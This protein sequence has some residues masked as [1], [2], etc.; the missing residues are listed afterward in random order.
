M[1]SLAR[2]AAFQTQGLKLVGQYRACFTATCASTRPQRVVV[3]GGGLAGL[4][5]SYHLLNQTAVVAQAGGVR[6]SP[7]RITIFDEC[8]VGEGGASGA[9]AGLLHP[10]TPRGKKMW[11]G[12]EGFDSSLR[13][14]QAAVEASSQ[15]ILSSSTGKRGILRLVTK[16]EKQLKDYL[17][18]A[19]LAP[20]EL[21]FVD[22]RSSID[23]A[24]GS[25]EK[26][27]EVHGGRGAE[28]GKR[29]VMEGVNALS[30]DINGALLVKQ[31]LALR[32]TRYTRGLLAA[33]RL[34]GEVSWQTQRI[35][36]VHEL[37]LKV[38]IEAEADG[39]EVA[40]VVIACGAACIQ[41][42]ELQ[43]LPISPVRAQNIIYEHSGSAAPE[44][45]FDALQLPIISGRYVVPFAR[46][47]AEA[48]AAQFL[49]A[50]ASQ[51]NPT[52]A[53]ECNQLYASANLS[54]ALELIE[55]D[56][57]AI[58][59]TLSAEAKT[60]TPSHARAGV[61]GVA[62]R[63]ALGA[64]PLCGRLH[65]PASVGGGQNVDKV[66]LLAG[67]GSRGLI[68]HSILANA[69]ARAVL[70]SD[71]QCIPAAA[72]RIRPLGGPELQ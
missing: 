38:Q 7:L 72:R 54:K 51:E 5:V 14:I 46:D 26:G 69:L 4:A 34:L 37:L 55:H 70:G 20:D 40:A 24:G 65:L 48:G 8:E 10:L 42:P 2:V 6:K 3:L 35:S 43:D 27:V 64:I 25:V 44:E 17:R 63:S 47:G 68:H 19:E 29:K 1:L 36:S 59:P 23:V 11:L 32:G 16:G 22:L 62:A 33:C 58:C 61:K 28:A 21:S 18:A 30:R 50:G 15:L 49:V 56:L 13:L 12:D 66:W 52:D 45:A 71:D 67:L 41:L 53:K 60:W 39:V 31:G 57:V 9:M